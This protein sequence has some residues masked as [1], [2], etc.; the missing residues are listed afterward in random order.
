MPSTAR[1]PVPANGVDHV[2]GERLALPWGKIEKD[3]LFDAPEGRVPLSD[4]FEG[5]SQLI[6]KHYMMAPGQRT[7]CVGCAFE[8]DHMQGALVHLRNHDV[9]YAAVARAPTEEIEAFRERMGWRFRFVSSYRSDFNYDFNVSFPPEK[10]HGPRRGLD[11]VG[12]LFDHESVD[13]SE[14]VVAHC[15]LSLVCAVGCEHLTSWRG[16]RSATARQPRPYLNRARPKPTYPDGGGVADVGQARVAPTRGPFALRTYTH[17]PSDAYMCA[18]QRTLEE[19][20]STPLNS[21]PW[22]RTKAGR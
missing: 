21:P 12:P 15:S 19:Y 13:A 20:L 3:Y 2:S 8:V 18:E 14:P 9:S 10:A 22:V 4:L 1:C 17:R 16:C 11:R 5:R 7:P 6:V